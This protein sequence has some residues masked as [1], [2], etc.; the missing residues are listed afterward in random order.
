MSKRNMVNVGGIVDPFSG[1]QRG[2]SGIAQTFGAQADAEAKE[3]ARLD[4]LALDRAAAEESKRRFEQNRSDTLSRNK[5]LDQRYKDEQAILKTERDRIDKERKQKK[6]DASILDNFSVDRSLEYLGPNVRNKV[7]QYKETS[8]KEKERILGNVSRL[9]LERNYFDKDNNLSQEGQKEYNKRLEG[10]IQQNVPLALAEMSALNDVTAIRDNALKS[11]YDKQAESYVNKIDRNY[12]QAIERLPSTMTT[13][14]FV[15]AGMK[16]LAD[17]GHSAPRS[18]AVRESLLA[19]AQ[20][21]GLTTKGA[22]QSSLTAASDADYQRQKDK[23]DIGI[24]VYNA[25]KKS[26]SGKPSSNKLKGMGEKDWREYVNDLDAIGTGDRDRANDL[27]A[28]MQ[29]DPRLANVDI[30]VLREAAYLTDVTTLGFDKDVLDPK[31]PKQLETAIEMAVSLS[32]GKTSGAR[33]VNDLKANLE[34]KNPTSLNQALGNRFSVAA[35]AGRPGDRQALP[36]TEYVAELANRLTTPTGP[37][38][39]EFDTLRAIEEVGTGDRSNYL[40]PASPT[41]SQEYADLVAKIANYKKQLETLPQRDVTG[42]SLRRS[43]I[44]NNLLPQAERDLN[45]LPR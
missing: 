12:E 42:T 27:V 8:D 28:T 45:S 40:V 43:Y 41:R 34:Y 15:A 19:R 39:R 26:K 7:A 24:K 11:D 17:A 21:L 31:N 33:I 32:N 1:L 22:M 10:Y 30:G 5:V 14:E 37:V 3:K 23:V 25:N 38:P 44:E 18:N 6:T 20:S 13:D 16:Q 29:K 35:T 9:L 2:L 4:N 36:S